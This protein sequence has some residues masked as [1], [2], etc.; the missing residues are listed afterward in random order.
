[1]G[2]ELLIQFV[3]LFSLFEAEDYFKWGVGKEEEIEGESCSE[4]INLLLDT[5]TLQEH[6]SQ[7]HAGKSTGMK[8]FC[9]TV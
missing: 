2:L 3:F 9:A 6:M 1:M 4:G 5:D 7:L 8:Q